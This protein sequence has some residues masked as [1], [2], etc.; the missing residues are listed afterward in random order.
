MLQLLTTATFPL[1]D[2]DRFGLAQDFLTLCGA[3]ALCDGAAVV[4]V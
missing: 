4:C 1:L 2:R 3:L